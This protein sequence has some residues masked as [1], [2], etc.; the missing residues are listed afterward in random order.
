MSYDTEP[1][2]DFVCNV[3]GDRTEQHKDTDLCTLCF[4]DK[5]SDLHEDLEN[6][7]SFTISDFKELDS[8]CD[9]LG[10]DRVSTEFIKRF[11]A[12]FSPNQP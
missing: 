1:E 6:L 3:C 11:T 8:Q 5:E 12:A 7:F 10:I 2:R 4:G 9:N